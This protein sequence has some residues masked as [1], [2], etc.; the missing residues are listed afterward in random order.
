MCLR[1]DLRAAQSREENLRVM[2]IVADLHAGQRNHAYPRVL[3]FVA[4]QVCQI[5]LDLVRYTP[6]SGRVLCH[7]P[8]NG[9]TAPTG[10]GAAKRGCGGGSLQSTRDLDDFVNFELVT[11]LEIVEVLD[12]QP[13]FETGLHLAYIVLEALEGIQFTGIDHHIVPEHADQ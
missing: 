13:A 3:E 5:P 12:R 10:I 11:D 2:V 6:E 4:D 9:Y 1:N 8:L 7:V